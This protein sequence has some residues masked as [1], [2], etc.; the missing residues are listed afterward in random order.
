MWTETSK[1]QM[2]IVHLC[3]WGFCGSEFLGGVADGGRRVTKGFWAL[4]TSL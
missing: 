1:E 3:S 4:T 2:A